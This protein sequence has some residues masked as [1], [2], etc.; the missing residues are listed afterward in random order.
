MTKVSIVGTAGR[1]QKKRHLQTKKLFNKMVE[2]GNHF[3]ANVTDLILI[4]GGAAWSDHVAIRMYLMGIADE[5]ILH[6]PCEFLVDEEKFDNSKYG[7]ISNYHHNRF[8][9]DI[10]YDSLYEIKLAIEKGAKVHVHNGFFKRNTEVAKCDYL[11]AMTWNEGDKPPVSGGTNDTWNKCKG[12]KYHLSLST[13][14]SQ[15]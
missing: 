4:S 10:G 15:T 3:V 5:L 1:D 12:I 11:L 2:I 8:S 6:L 7:I 9:N 14:S 13:I